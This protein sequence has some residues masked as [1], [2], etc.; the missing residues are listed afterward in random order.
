[1]SLS[2]LSEILFSNGVEKFTAEEHLDDK[3][4]II[5]KH[6]DTFIALNRTKTLKG[7]MKN[8]GLFTAI[9]NDGA[10][11]GDVVG[12]TMA[13]KT[14]NDKIITLTFQ[15]D[16]S[17]FNNYSVFEFRETQQGFLPPTEEEQNFGDL[18]CYTKASWEANKPLKILT[19][20][21]CVITDYKENITPD[22]EE[23][24]IPP[25]QIPKDEEKK[26]EYS[27]EEVPWEEED[28]TFEWED[29]DE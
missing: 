18:Y 14:L 8:T 11:I 9:V 22:S 4:N 28:Q 24:I 1:M 27:G 16:P 7:L 3:N 26:Q 19:F 15:Y 5:L 6:Q 25:I 13:Y 23:V 21:G 10:D 29:M 12:M 17:V 2:K 20:G